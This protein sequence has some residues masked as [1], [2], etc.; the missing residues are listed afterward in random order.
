[1]RMETKKM[2]TMA[3]LSAIS[4][5]LVMLIRI[6]CPGAAFLEYDPADVPIL[7]ST[8]MFGP[9]WGLAV[10]V[11][12]SVIQ[13]VS[14]SAGSGIIG[15]IMH[16]FATGTY[17]IVTGLINKKGSDKMLVLSLVAGAL[18]ST[19][20]MVV[21]NLIFTPIFMGAPFEVVKNMMLPIILPFNLVKAGM[22]GI[23][24]GVVYF[25]LK[26]AKITA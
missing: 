1:M 7:L 17:V 11:V 22:N 6:P 2:V 3:M 19:A 8:V 12:V 5:I 16:I 15:I 9:W 13:G 24:A 18:A 14:V 4:V 20:F 26:K 10:T 25:I 23:F 21:W